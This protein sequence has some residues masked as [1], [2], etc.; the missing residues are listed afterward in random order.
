MKAKKIE[1]GDIYE[2]NEISEFNDF[3][4]L[5]I[6]KRVKMGKA[7]II[8]YNVLRFSMTANSEFGL[9]D[10]LKKRIEGENAIKYGNGNNDKQFAKLL[11]LGL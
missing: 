9:E 11:L 3:K 5:R 4:Y 2:F 10:T 8:R 7:W 6:V 1:V